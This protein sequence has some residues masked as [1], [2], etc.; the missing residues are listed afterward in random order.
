MS[1]D[2]AQPRGVRVS[3]RRVVGHASSLARLQRELAR[4]EMKQKG[5]SVGAGAGLG[6]ATAVVGFFALA[7]A[8]ATAAAALALIV[9]TWLALLIMFVLL[10]LL[11]VGL[12]LLAKSFVQKG[13]PLAPEQALEEAR[14]TKLA[15]RRSRGA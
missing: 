11:T 7:F 10:L 6:I 2:P 12:A 1:M 13:T 14:L 3:V 9:D 5:A 4:V 15:L 8:L